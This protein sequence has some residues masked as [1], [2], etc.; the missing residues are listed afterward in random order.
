MAN[1]VIQAIPLFLQ[2]HVSSKDSF[3][4][5]HG[6]VKEFALCLFESILL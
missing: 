4:F 5:G 1:V 2:C 6:D 3:F